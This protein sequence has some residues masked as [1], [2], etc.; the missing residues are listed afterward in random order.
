[1]VVVLHLLGDLASGLLPDVERQFVEPL[2]DILQILTVGSLPSFSWIERVDP[3]ELVVWNQLIDEFVVESDPL[4]VLLSSHSLWIG[5]SHLLPLFSSQG[6]LKLFTV[7]YA[8]LQDLQGV[9][10]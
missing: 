6:S 3:F 5:L 9:L 8:E 7:L 4:S 1:M 10:Y 2:I